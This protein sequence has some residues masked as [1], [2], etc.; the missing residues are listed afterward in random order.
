M[1]MKYLTSLACIFTSLNTVVVA[2]EAIR[3]LVPSGCEKTLIIAQRHVLQP[4]VEERTRIEMTQKLDFYDYYQDRLDWCKGIKNM[5]EFCG[6]SE[7]E[8]WT[9]ERNT[10]G[11]ELQEIEMD[12]R[13]NPSHYVNCLVMLKKYSNSHSLLKE[14]IPACYDPNYDL[15]PLFG[16]TE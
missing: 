13:S 5:P 12:A 3:C 6:K 2:N 8:R 9:T 15:L 10:R 7:I 1:Q 11:R 4:S 16:V 14:N